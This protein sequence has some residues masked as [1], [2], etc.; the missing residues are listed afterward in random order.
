MF[1]I[2]SFEL[3]YYL[4]LSNAIEKCENIYN[5]KDIKERDDYY[6]ILNNCINN[7]YF[8]KTINHRKLYIHHLDVKK[9]FFIKNLKYKDYSNLLNQSKN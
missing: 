8:H 5:V 2:K 7:Y 9:L 6:Q 1:N 3:N 4:I